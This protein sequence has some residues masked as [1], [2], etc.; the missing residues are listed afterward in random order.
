M[1]FFLREYGVIGL[2]DQAEIVCTQVMEPVVEKVQ[3]QNVLPW[4]PAV[5]QPLDE[6]E[7]VC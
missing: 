2:G 4:D 5:Q 7:Q 1:F 3:V 6:L